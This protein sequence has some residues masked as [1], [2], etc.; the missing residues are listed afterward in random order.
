MGHALTYVYLAAFVC[1][2]VLAPVLA[3]A[4]PPQRIRA[5]RVVIVALIA[6]W[7]FADFLSNLAE[8]SEQ[9]E[10]LARIFVFVWAP[11]PFTV[12]LTMLVYT[13]WPAWARRRWLRAALAL[14]VIGC[15][16]L[17]QSGALY[18]EFLPASANGHY[19]QSRPTSWQFFVTAYTILYASLSAA[20]LLGAARRDGRKQFWVTGA[21]LLRTLVPVVVVSNV[22]NGGL[23]VFGIDPPYLGS[24]F[25]SGV[26]LAVGIGTLK[27][28]HFAP[29][30]TILRERDAARVNLSR[31]EEILAALPVGV[32]IV[33]P[34]TCE[35]LYA[36]PVFKRIREGSRNG[37]ELQATTE[38]LVRQTL[39]SGRSEPSEVR[40]PSAEGIRTLLFAAHRVQYGER[41]AV[42][43]T[44]RDIT[45]TRAMEAEIAEQRQRIAQAQKMEAV[46]RLSAGIAHD[47]NNQLS[48]IAT[49]ADLMA[50]ALADEDRYR[51]DL[52]DIIGAVERGRRL[53]SQLLAFSRKQT[54]KATVLDVNEVLTGL[55]HVLRRLAGTT[56]TLIVTTSPTRALIRMDR[57]HLEQ[58]VMALATNA[59][60]AMPE[61]GELALDVA[62]VD[63]SAS[64]HRRAEVVVR[65]RDTGC[66]IPQEVLG[67]IFD[68]FFTTKGE[69]GTGLGLATAYGYMRVA[70]ASIAVGSEVGKGT[71]FTLRFRAVP[72]EEAPEAHEAAPLHSNAADAPPAPL[73][74]LLVDDEDRVRRGLVRVL[75]EEGHQVLDACS[76]DEALRLFHAQHVDLLITDV[77]M[78]AKDGHALAAELRQG[79]PDLPV[80]FMSG[81]VEGERGFDGDTAAFLPKPIRPRAL[82]E[83]LAQMR[84]RMEAA[85]VRP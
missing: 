58:V 23:S 84:S 27:Q 1:M 29:I 26:A 73:T 47:F 44:A 71:E 43:V 77:A 53:T 19:F 61:G 16:V 31:R 54:P 42:L 40:V 28:E 52:E 63:A 13:G 10:L 2:T 21:M 59:A 82:L 51:Q 8:T 68:P 4:T 3:V 30:A 50:A 72:E 35:V 55:E 17:V 24:V 25:C 60:D 65:V 15:V 57:S 9:V 14:P 74:V 66:G 20:V 7:T 11:L 33:E 81:H 36:N 45:E 34:D 62:C 56:V 22:L 76:A 41:A 70:K 48:V 32:A 5:L 49:N 80:L 85:R 37:A 64:R 67:S 12:L 18:H 79:R 46:G 78:P 38:G 69:L 75:A 83:V 39:A 6:G